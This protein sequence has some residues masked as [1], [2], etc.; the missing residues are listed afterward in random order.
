SQLWRRP[1]RWNWQIK[2]TDRTS[3]PTN[4]G[5][6]NPMI[7][8]QSYPMLTMLG[9]A[10]FALLEELPLS[11]MISLVIHNCQRSS[12]IPIIIREA[13]RLPSIPAMIAPVSP[14]TS[15]AAKAFSVELM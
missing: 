13:V 10:N 1:R 14:T 5:H 6:F 2:K 11:E 7:C 3:L 8:G 4:R 15:I 12:N 9:S